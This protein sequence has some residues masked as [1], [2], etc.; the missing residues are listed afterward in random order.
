MMGFQGQLSLHRVFAAIVMGSSLLLGATN[1]VSPASELP[2]VL[3][4]GESDGRVA[5]KLPA[6]AIGANGVDENAMTRAL[7]R[8]RLRDQAAGTYIDE[9]LLR[10]DSA[11]ARW[12][13]EKESRSRTLTVWIQPKSD[14]ADFSPEFAKRV[15]DAFITWDFVGL[16]GLHFAFTTDSARANIRVSWTDRFKEPISG[17]TRWARDGGWWI[18]EASILLAVHHSS[19]DALNAESVGALALHEVGH[20][21]GLDHT[22]DAANV[23]AAK[24]RVRGLSEAD[25]ATA[26]LLY[27]LPAGAIR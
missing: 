26:R 4:Y 23:M 27:S 5:A 2:P 11:L 18:T 24:V 3:T 10:R 13:V 14:I 12:K 8:S 7:T 9:I 6:D 25:E 20:L 15:R 21:I 17:R 16:N 22:T 1:G 19:G